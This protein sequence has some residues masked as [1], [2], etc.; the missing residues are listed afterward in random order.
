MIDTLVFEKCRAKNFFSIGNSWMEFDLC[1]A[2]RTLIVGPNGAGKSTVLEIITYCLF[3]KPY[4]D[5]KLGQV[6]NSVNGKDCLTEVIFSVRG[7]RYTVTRGQSPSVF[8]IH[9]DGELVTQDASNRDYQQVLEKQILRWNLK[10]FKQIVAVGSASYVPFMK[11]KPSDRRAVIEDILDISIFTKMGDLSRATERALKGDI[12]KTD[13]EIKQ[14]STWTQTLSSNLSAMM[15]D[16]KAVEQQKASELEKIGIQISE[17]QLRM[18]EILSEMEPI[19]SKVEEHTK[20]SRALDSLTI[21]LNAAAYDVRNFSGKIKNIE[22]ETHC[23]NCGQEIPPDKRESAV[24]SLRPSLDT[25][26]TTLASLKDIESKMSEKINSL[27][28]YSLALNELTAAARQTATTLESLNAQQRVWLSK[29]DESFSAMETIQA[30]IQNTN[31]KLQELNARYRELTDSY[32]YYQMASAMLKDSGIKSTVVSNYL[33]VI[34]KLI[35]TYLEEFGL[36][37]GFE[38]SSTFEETIRSRHRDLFSYESFS[39]GEQLII[40][41][42]I[43]YTWRHICT[44]KSTMSCNLLF[45]DEVGGASLDSS[46]I[47]TMVKSLGSVASNIF[48]IS[49]REVDE[50]D[51]DRVWEFSKVNKFSHVTERTS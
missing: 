20:L 50:D 2:G 41:L 35:N 43:M 37:V 29:T 44:L 25:A 3:N 51:F 22:T 14:N 5:I 31:L 4:R 9:K 38:L 24:A 36:F 46:N 40:D 7:S 30:D 15:A 21:K 32:Q 47:E 10:A 26:S 48:L 39:V 34:N 13:S 23:E 8:T 33:P 45:F 17:N 12:Q 1:G 6:V 18:S 16:K 28:A 11:L 27:E 49:H 19:K 42:A